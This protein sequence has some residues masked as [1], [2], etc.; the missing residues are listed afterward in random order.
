MALIP[1]VRA[2]HSS[3]NHLPKT[4]IPNTFTFGFGMQILGEHVHIVAACHSMVNFK[5]LPGFVQ[6]LDGEHRQLGGGRHPG[7][8]V[9]LSGQNSEKEEK[10]F[11]YDICGR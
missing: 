1:F 2:P 8:E 3:P 9:L 7:L 6:P 5:K 10:L 4:V 11:V